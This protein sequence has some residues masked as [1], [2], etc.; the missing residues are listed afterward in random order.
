MLEVSSCGMLALGD[1][2]IDEKLA[3]PFAF[4]V[5]VPVVPPPL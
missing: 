2:G 4:P 1:A 5:A 3:E